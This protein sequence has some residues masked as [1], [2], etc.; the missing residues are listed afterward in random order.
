M[1]YLLLKYD[2]I[3][4]HCFTLDNPN[5]SIYKRINDSITY[6]SSF[7]LCTSTI[8]QNDIGYTNYYTGI[9]IILEK[10]NVTFCSPS[11][12]GTKRLDG[13]LYFNEEIGTENPSYEKIE[14]S[15][16]NRKKYNEFL[17]TNYNPIGIFISQDPEGWAYATHSINS[18]FETFYNQTSGFGL[19]YYFLKNGRLSLLKYD[20]HNKIF[21]VVKAVKTND[22]YTMKPQEKAQIF[23]LHFLSERAIAEMQKINCYAELIQSLKD[24][25]FIEIDK[26]NIYFNCFFSPGSMT[27]V[28]FS[29]PVKS[30]LINIDIN[31]LK[32][33][34]PKERIAILLHE[35][36]HA[37]Y[38]GTDSHSSEFNADDFA[39]ERGYGFVLKESLT[40]NI[41]ENPQE[42]D[43]EI[44]RLRIA[45]ISN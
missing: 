29:I 1:N 26:K 41:T 16:R 43:K 27:D 7:E 4:S 23:D 38:P 39:I 35:L 10:P 14:L 17:V 37:I 3:L 45:R 9:G 20:T 36:G 44:T 40:R 42:F 13:V 5:G 34:N 32:R 15:I 28:R 31:Y 22:I 8:H 33:L 18:D 30:K 25:D 11:D 2:C 24:D 19:P 12:G 6:N 21:Q